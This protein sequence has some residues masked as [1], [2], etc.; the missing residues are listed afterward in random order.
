[1]AKNS[2]AKSVEI[3]RWV[4]EGKSPYVVVNLPNANKKAI[5][6][7]NKNKKGK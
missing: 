5:A 3:G 2:K 4:T 6:E 1:M 7:M